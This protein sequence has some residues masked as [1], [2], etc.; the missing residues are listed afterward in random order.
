MPIID[1]DKV[2]EWEKNEAVDTLKQCGILPGMTV[3]DFGCGLGHYTIPA[4]I[5]TGANG[6]VLAIDSDKWI[7]SEMDNRI[8]EHHIDNITLY[9]MDESGLSQFKNSI[10][11]IMYYDMFHAHKEKNQYILEAFYNSLSENGTLSFSVFNEI[12]L[13]QDPINGPKT[14]TGKPSWFRIPYEE[15]LKHYNVM[16]QIESCGFQ[17]SNVL[18]G[19]G[20]HFD[21]YWRRQRR[22]DFVSLERRNIYNFRKV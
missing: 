9:R 18:E 12:E 22:Q 2:H 16:D 7:V 20:V 6:K 11:F 21:D 17:L 4:S 14:P 13:I 3:M 5:A 15:A 10:D 19:K 8:K 1:M